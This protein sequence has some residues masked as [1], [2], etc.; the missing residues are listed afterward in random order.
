MGKLAFSL[1]GH[2]DAQT[3]IEE[4]LPW[5]QIIEK[6]LQSD[7]LILGKSRSRPGFHLFS[8]H[9]AQRVIEN[10]TCPVIVVPNWD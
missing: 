1:S 6:S 5:E 8:K 3:A 9:T 10:A 4:G 2:V 7:V